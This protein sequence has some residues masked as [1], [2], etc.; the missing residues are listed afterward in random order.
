VLQ[1]RENLNI[2]GCTISP[3]T[4]DYIRGIYAY[5]GSTNNIV[6]HNTTISGFNK[7]N[8]AGIY[9]ASTAT[10]WQIRN[11][12]FTGNNQ[13]I[14]YECQGTGNFIEKNTFT[15]NTH[16]V[17][18][19]GQ[20]GIFRNNTFTANVYGI[21]IRGSPPHYPYYNEFYDNII[22]G[23]TTQAIYFY[24]VD[25]LQ[26]T[27]VN[28]TVNGQPYIHGYGVPLTVRDVVITEPK[29]TNYGAINIYGSN[30]YLE[31]VTVRY[32]GVYGIYVRGGTNITINGSTIASNA[33]H[34]MVLDNNMGSG[35]VGTKILDTTIAQNGKQGIV[36]QN[37]EN[38]NISGCTISPGT[39]DY[40][41]GIYA[42]GG[43]TNN[44]VIHNTTISGFNK[45][46]SAG[47][48]L[49]STATNWQIR[50]SRFTGNYQGIIYESQ[51][52]G[53]I[54]EENTFTSNTRGVYIYPGKY[55][56]F[57]RNT[58]RYN[59]YGIYVA[60]TNNQIYMNNFHNRTSY[61]VYSQGNLDNQ[62]NLTAPIGGNY[63]DDYATVMGF[64]CSD[65]NADGFCDIPY[66]ISGSAQ[67]DYLPY[68]YEISFT[69]PVANFTASPLSGTA[70]LLVQFNDTSTGEPTSWLW[71]FGDGDT[72]NYTLQHP[73]HTYV[74]AGSYTVS[75]N[76]TN[77]AGSNTTTKV[78]YITVS[79]GGGGGNETLT[80][81]CDLCVNETGWW[82]DNGMFHESDTPI[83]AAVN[84]ANASD[85]ICITDG[86]YTEN[87]DI[88]TD[89]ITI[90][91]AN[92]SAVTTVQALN[93]NDHVF[94]VTADYVNISGFTVLN[95]TGAS[96]ICLETSE[97]SF[98]MNNTISANDVGI[99]LQNSAH[100]TIENN[101]I[102]HNYHSSPFSGIHLENSDYSTIANNT[103]IDNDDG[104]YLLYSSFNIIRDNDASSNDYCGIELKW[105]DNNSI[106]NNTASDN[107][108]GI[109]LSYSGNNAL[110]NNTFVNNGLFVSNSYA[111]SVT[112]NTVNG[113]PL[114][115]REAV[116]DQGI[117]DA[118]QVILVNC[119][120]ITVE[121][122]EV[123]NASVGM[124]LWG[125][126]NSTI[127]NITASNNI[128]T[129]IYLLYS[130]NNTLTNNTATSNLNGVYL[131]YS[132]NNTLTNNTATSDLN[133]FYLES[134]S[135]YN[136]LINNTATSNSYGIEIS[137]SS[138]NAIEENI[139]SNNT[140]G[141]DLWNSSNNNITGNT[142]NSN[143]NF[144]LYLGSSTDN[145]IYN[146]Y[147]SNTNN[148]YDDGTNSW[149]ITATFG[150]NIIGG[151]YIGGN[152][153]SDYTGNDSTSDGLGETP[154]PIPPYGSNQDHLPLAT[155]LIA[156]TL[157]NSSIEY[158][159]V[160]EY[161]S[162]TSPYINVTNT[163]TVNETFLIRGDE[164]YY[165]LNTLYFWTLAETL[166]ED[167]YVHQFNNGTIDWPCLNKTE[168]L[169]LA[170]YVPLGGNVTFQLRITLPSEIS[171]P[172]NYTTTVTI[173]ATEAS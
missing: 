169:T 12:R 3:G 76:V 104:V 140:R 162:Q 167:Q 7:P 117:T 106:Y 70:P 45:P 166:G 50:N 82:Y 98:I 148:S 75:L 66:N 23:S 156:L 29:M 19:L 147:F 132:S 59:T 43:S 91:S 141:I 61:H 121:N 108:Y 33:N 152:Y 150:Q 102:S 44:I 40:I 10:N 138:N 54:I 89:G 13:G 28:N 171:H 109:Y 119:D 100:I 83:Q 107:D 27:F 60:S 74:N 170:E 116:S 25:N 165:V 81:D 21:Y 158:G 16:G 51:G 9:L 94:N 53:N 39:D 79:D 112:D 111:N 135:D 153:W 78:G 157:S 85:T 48:Y 2:S 32:H 30:M 87:V 57:R 15:S 55:G 80:C 139:A 65:G 137:S 62:Y 67:K 118:G 134:S 127:M 146:N 64:I 142:A 160:A 159:T 71:D 72:T 95:A 88:T 35:G 11:S 18:A 114:A 52:T 1:N 97:Y 58:F 136:N 155:R 41:R 42:Y 31:N 86:T 168:S 14:N 122:I 34:G 110:T 101:T 36:L 8:S 123:V 73:L 154:Y 105:S 38:L 69:P 173:M 133:G 143:T 22:N 120:N 126:T 24:C 4:D 49:A 77:A 125:T 68:V 17:S 144:G 99:S 92:G 90:Q 129:G 172:G 113:K 47:I 63:W 93:E 103:I 96:G 161:G 130:S 20:Y 124:E 37:R 46:N 164:A 128:D 145:T 149:N 5:G 163:G 56:V 6:I 131:C 26:N 151:P 115:Y 84:N